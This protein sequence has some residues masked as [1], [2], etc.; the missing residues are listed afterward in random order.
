MEELPLG[1]QMKLR[2]MPGAES[3]TQ[4]VEVILEDGRIVP[5]V[6]VVD[7]TYVS[8][9]TF[10]PE[11]VAD[12]R[13]PAQPPSARGVALFLGL[14]LLGIFMMFYLLRTLAPE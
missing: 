13:L 8:D 14:L 6:T 12:V 11:M 1:I 5:T 2:E 10:E 4:V 9:E 7:C 3:G